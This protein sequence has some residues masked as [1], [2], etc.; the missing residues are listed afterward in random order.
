MN[1]QLV[2]KRNKV[3]EFGEHVR[4]RQVNRQHGSIL[5]PL[6]NISEQPKPKVF[7]LRTRRNLGLVVAL[8]CSPSCKNDVVYVLFVSGLLLFAE[9]GH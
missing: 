1:L 7:M 6:I 3:D 5:V 9:E 4:R 2:V 8:A